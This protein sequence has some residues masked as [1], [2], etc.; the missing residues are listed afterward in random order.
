[1]SVVTYSDQNT[2]LGKCYIT[3]SYVFL[4]DKILNERDTLTYSLCRDGEV[5]GYSVQPN[6]PLTELYHIPCYVVKFVFSAV[7]TLHQPGQEAVMDQLCAALKREVESVKGYYVL[8]IP[9]HIVDL[10]RAVNRNL[11]RILFCGGTVEEIYTESS[12]QITWSREIEVLFADR[13]FVETHRQQLLSMALRSFQNYQGQY[14]ISPVTSGNAGEIYR[15]WI[16]HTL[17]DYKENALIVVRHGQELAGY[18]TLRED[19]LAVEAVLGSVNQEKRRLGVY[20]AMFYT[21]IQY[22]KEKGKLFLSSTQFDNYIVQGTW[23]ALG[24]RPFYSIYNVHFDN[25]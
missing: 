17:D 23:S 20:K 12:K 16:E 8:R 25:R 21:L 4:H 3:R 11:N 18:C 6:Q 19:T 15:R 10:I 1:M 2:L 24:L 7:D 5:Y 22:A 14:H 13:L 9:A